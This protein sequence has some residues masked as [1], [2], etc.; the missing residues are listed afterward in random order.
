MNKLKFHIRRRND[1]HDM[2]IITNSHNNFDCLIDTG[3]RV[4]VWCAGVQVLKV[5]YPDCVR[6]AAIFILRGF[7]RGYEVVDVYKIPDFI[8]SD[9]RQRIHYR[10]MLVAVTDRDY[11]F[12]MILSYN[13]FN[14][15]NISI[16]TFTD[17]GVL[18][19]I[20]PDVK[21]SSP[22]EMY[23]VACKRVDIRSDKI[24]EIKS[25]F[26]TINILD[27]VCIFNQQ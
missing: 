27:S 10:N 12:N 3:A 25:K 8:L 15:M 6:Q 13:M 4:P 14:K 9:G 22:K 16:N 20:E 5:Y 2:V 1:S 23:N 24:E 19:R 17:K 26:G 18:H 7:G 21:I 11:A